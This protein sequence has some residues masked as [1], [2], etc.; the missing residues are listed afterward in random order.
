MMI[1]TRTVDAMRCRDMVLNFA[2]FVQLSESK[3]MES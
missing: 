1:K 2:K 3:K